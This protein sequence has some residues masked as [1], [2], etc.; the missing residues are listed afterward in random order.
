[1]GISAQAEVSAKGGEGVGGGGER[2]WNLVAIT[3]RVLSRRAPSLKLRGK[4]R[5]EQN[6]N[7]VKNFQLNFWVIRSLPDN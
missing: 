2:D 1:M 7:S 6:Q 5:N 3:S 4:V